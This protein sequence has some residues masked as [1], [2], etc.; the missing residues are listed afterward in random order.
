MVPRI[1]AEWRIPGLLGRGRVVA[2]AAA[3]PK[4]DGCTC[5]YPLVCS[6][7][8][9]GRT[10]GVQMTD[11]RPAAGSAPVADPD[12][13]DEVLL[14]GPDGDVC[15]RLGEP[16]DRKALRRAVTERA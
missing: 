10:R 1:T 3:P 5:L 14:A 4:S 12:W 13:V 7:F 11:A 9:E 8:S 2:T 16:I 6:H 15:L